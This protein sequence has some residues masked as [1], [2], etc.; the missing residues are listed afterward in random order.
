MTKML[1]PII[2]YEVVW[3]DTKSSEREWKMYNSMPE[4]LNFA[5]KWLP[6]GTPYKIFRHENRLEEIY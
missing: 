6:P 2:K 5:D 3:I 1:K 4:A